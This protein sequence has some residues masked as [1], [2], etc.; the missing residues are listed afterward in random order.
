MVTES[1]SGSPV[2]ESAYADYEQ[3][4]VNDDVPATQARA[5]RQAL[6][7]IVD[8]LMLSLATK[9]DLQQLRGELRHEMRELR[10]DLRQ[11]IRE[12]RIDHGGQ[13]AQLLQDVSALKAEMRLLNW[14]LAMF[15]PASISLMSA[16]LVVLL[17]R[18]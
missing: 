12:L 6:E 1:Q 18:L 17:T 7:R 16:V 9:A 2:P 8:R 4:L 13:I 10:H 3:D 5:S 14:M 15:G 11:E